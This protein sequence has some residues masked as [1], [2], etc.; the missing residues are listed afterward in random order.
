ME[1]TYLRPPWL[2][3]SY[4]SRSVMAEQMAAV[5]AAADARVAALE[6]QVNHRR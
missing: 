5:E 1:R 6:L 3:G 2:S 4:H